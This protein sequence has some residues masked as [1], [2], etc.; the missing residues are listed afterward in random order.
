MRR[1]TTTWGTQPGKPQVDAMTVTIDQQKLRKLMQLCHPDKHEGSA[2][3][4]DIFQWL[5]EIKRK[6]LDR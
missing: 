4:L 2:T 5:Q 6:A 3:A 1:G